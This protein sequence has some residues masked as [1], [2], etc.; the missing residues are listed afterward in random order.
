ML[1]RRQVSNEDRMDIH[2]NARLTPH[3]RAELVRRVIG[4]GQS[5][6]AVAEAF[7]AYQRT[8]RKW[9]KRFDRPGAFD[10]TRLVPMLEELHT[11]LSAGDPVLHRPALLRLRESL[12]PLPLRAGRLRPPGRA[13]RR[14]QGPLHPLPERP[15]GDPRAFRT[16]PHEPSQDQLHGLRQLQRHG[17]AGADYQRRPG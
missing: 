2:T 4:E 8:V 5:P 10:V 6:R 11:R 3:S 1:S 13:A 14:P 17:R 7:G 16:V 15:P 12:W 9:V